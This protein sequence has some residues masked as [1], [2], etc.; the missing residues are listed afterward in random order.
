MAALREADNCNIE[1]LRQFVRNLSRDL[2]G[3]GA[4]TWGD[5]CLEPPK[6]KSLSALFWGLITGFFVCPD[7]ER[8][9]VENVF[10]EHLI[11]ARKGNKPDALTNWVAK[12]F[13]PFWDLLWREHLSHVW[14][15]HQ[16]SNEDPEKRDSVSSSDKDN[17]TVYS[18]PWIVRVTSIITTVVACLLPIV[19]I[20][21]LSRIRRMG[22]ILG[23][24]AIFTAVFAV[25][26]VLL[27]STSS[28]VE[29]FTATAA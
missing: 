17:F 6:S 1:T 20:T 2:S 29:I 22:L 23:L 26:L 14:R 28:R 12:S 24:I 9:P 13:I 3:D 18:G 4:K 16:T 19:A 10:Q 15:K 27:S 7:V 5:R 8:K 25:G 11:V 21:V